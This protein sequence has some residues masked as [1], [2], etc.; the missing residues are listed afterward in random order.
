MSGHRRARDVLIGAG[1]AL[2][3]SALLLC[4][5]NRI[6]GMNAGERATAAVEA[7]RREIARVSPP[8]ETL[9]PEL[10]TEMTVVEL[11]GY[12][13]IGWL[14]IPELKLELPVMADWD[15]ERLRIAPCR[16]YGSAKSG[17]L[18]IAAHNYPEHFG[19][20]SELSAGAV[21]YFTDMDGQRREYAA[22]EIERLGPEDVEQVEHSGHELVLYTCTPGGERCVTVFC[23]ENAA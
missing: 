18:V 12:G 10:D 5:Y 13:Y 21:I 4:C 1:A 22:S 23:D 20:L 19:G 14:Y 15:Y 9:E 2:I 7:V 11:D 17:D 16:E 8:P 6:E 3:L